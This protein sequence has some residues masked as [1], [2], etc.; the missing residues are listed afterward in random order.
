MVLWILGKCEVYRSRVKESGDKKRD[1]NRK[2]D[3]G[4]VNT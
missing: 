1:P 3:D 2:K 4:P